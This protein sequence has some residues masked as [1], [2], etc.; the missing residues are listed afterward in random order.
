[1]NRAILFPVSG[2]KW[3]QAYLRDSLSFY[4]EDSLKRLLTSGQCEL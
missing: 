1:M 3:T 2:L 4:A